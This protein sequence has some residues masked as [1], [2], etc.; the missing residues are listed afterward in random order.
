MDQNLSN[1]HKKVKNLSPIKSN[2]TVSKTN[3]NNKKHITK[4]DLIEINAIK[5]NEPKVQ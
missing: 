4:S 2:E 1:F 5:K 3:I